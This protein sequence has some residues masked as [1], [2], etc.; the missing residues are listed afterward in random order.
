VVKRGKKKKLKWIMLKLGWSTGKQ[1]ALRWRCHPRQ[2]LGWA[3]FGRDST[4]VLK[5]QEEE[6]QGQRTHFDQAALHRDIILGS[7]ISLHIVTRVQV[8]PN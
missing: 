2:K 7:M 4:R 3:M 8:E 6:T 1:K 5:A